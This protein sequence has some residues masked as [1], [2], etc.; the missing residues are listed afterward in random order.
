MSKKLNGKVAV[1]T[2]ASGGIGYAITKQ[3]KKAGVKIY[4]ISLH[5]EEHEEMEKAY[6]CDVND[7]AKV[8]TILE[9]IF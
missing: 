2:G 7:T 4:D 8:K 6:A 1:I 3:L 9:E 5:V